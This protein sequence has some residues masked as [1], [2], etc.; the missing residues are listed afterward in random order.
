MHEAGD[1]STH[2]DLPI[3]GLEIRMLKSIQFPFCQW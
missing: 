3:V 2:S 1:S